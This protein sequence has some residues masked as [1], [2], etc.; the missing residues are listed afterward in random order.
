MFKAWSLDTARSCLLGLMAP[1]IILP[2]GCV[3]IFIPLWLVTEF[4][5]TIWVLIVSSI[6]YFLVV[7]GG[8][9]GATVWVLLRRK[10]RLDAVFTPL[11]LTGGQYMLT[12]RQY[13]GA[14]DGRQVSAR[15][16]RGP[17]LEVRLSTPLQTRFGVAEEGATTLPLAR[18]AGQQPLDLEAPELSG[19]HVFARDEG[20]ARSLLA[21]SEAR[22]R[23]R[24]LMNAAEDWALV[25]QVILEP[26]TFCL[27]LYRSR[28]LFKYE[29]RP[30][31]VR[32]WLDDLRA[33]ARI[34]ESA[35]PRSS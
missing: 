26:G 31:D 13:Q 22:T 23:I 29:I 9:I 28:H 14:V 4:D 32:Q 27:R 30:E 24:R 16:Y 10:R 11:G 25:R 5:V 33:L 20:W 2:L 7:V 34:A 1:A 19:L 18:L 17:T 15:F 21:D 6:L 12:G 35:S 3:C 8:G